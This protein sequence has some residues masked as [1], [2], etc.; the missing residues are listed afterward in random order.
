M[1]PLSFFNPRFSFQITPAFPTAWWSITGTTAP[2][3]S[4]WKATAACPLILSTTIEARSSCGSWLNH[5]ILFNTFQIFPETLRHC[6]VF[7][8]FISSALAARI[9]LFF[10]DR[11]AQPPDRIDLPQPGRGECVSTISVAGLPCCISET[12]QIETPVMTICGVSCNVGIL[13]LNLP[14]TQ[15]LLFYLCWL[16]RSSEPQLVFKKAM[17]L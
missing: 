17:S 4:E 15:G 8:V 16:Q 12:I 3:I 1:T 6:L 13:F 14:A 11:V 5:E 10:N 9:V 7:F 2:V